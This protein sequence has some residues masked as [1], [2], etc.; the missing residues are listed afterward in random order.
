MV[1][2]TLRIQ[3]KY[4]SDEVREKETSK[5]TETTEVSVW[6]RFLPQIIATMVKNLLLLD[7]GLSMAFPTIIIPALMGLNPENNPNERMSL[8]PMEAS[9][10]GSV[11]F[12]FQIVGSFLSG[13]VTEP[14]GRKRALILVNIPHVVGWIFCK[15]SKNLAHIYIAHMLFGL[16]IGLMEAPIMTY[17]GE[18]W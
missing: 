18:I 11:A 1:E 9:W 6:R 12:I 8:T 16:G 2:F 3:S 7:L 10:L 14:I 5:M 13:W 4:Y 17:V 15:F